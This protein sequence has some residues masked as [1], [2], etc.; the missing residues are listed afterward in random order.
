M[1]PFALVVLL[2]CQDPAPTPPPATSAPQSTPSLDVIE[3]KNGDT[4]EGRITA[5][6]DGY[7]ELTL[8]EGATIGVSTATV[9]RIRR[10]A[11]GAAPGPQVPL[12]VHAEWFVL[13]D[14]AGECV[15]WLRTT[16][17]TAADGSYTL[18]EEYEFVTGRRRFQVTSL[19]TAGA[20]R[21]PRSCYFRERQS[22]PVLAS[23]Q[24]GLGDGSQQERVVDERIVEAKVADGRLQVQR[25]D[26]HGRR[27]REFG[28]PEQASFPLLARTTARLGG[29]PIDA[30]PVFDPAT[31]EM[32]TRSYDG[33][34]RRRVVHDGE[35]MFVQEVAEASAAGRNSEWLDA[36]F[37]T[38]RRE[39]AGPSLVAVPSSAE[40][41]KLAV[42]ATSIPRA[43]V[44][45]A[46]GSFGLWLPNPAWAPRDEQPAGQVALVCEA[47]GAS[48]AL[49][50][51][52]H[53]EPGLSLDSAADAV[54]NWFSLLHPELRLGERQS[55]AVRERTAVRLLAQG[56]RARVAWRATVDVIPQRDRF[57]V[58]V[59]TAPSDAWDEL[60]PDF[61]FL[62]RS[63]ELEAQALAPRLQGPLA[64]GNAKGNDGAAAKPMAKAPAAAAP[65]PAGKATP[66]TP[67]PPARDIHVRIPD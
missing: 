3:L 18:G 46:G 37:H 38:L 2:A 25:L 21:K 6:V 11:G 56:R 62:L 45:E 28:W 40:S 65:S 9:A 17:S 32:A 30:L 60:A 66:V 13:H 29:A 36:Q 51:L 50:R 53:L 14:A 31:E 15:G 39:L 24:L 41:M 19:A 33:S 1:I 43:V 16:V 49:S 22:E 27:E 5:E 26:R 20:D 61:E 42:G 55:I 8:G 23:L 48:V 67:Q 59:C 10:G 7:V 52:D 64:A 63:I 34:R 57:V 35:P 4:L 47:H 54:A 12:P 58:L 44:A